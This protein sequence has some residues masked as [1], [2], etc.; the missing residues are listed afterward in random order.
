[1]NFIVIRAYLVEYS[2]NIMLQV[3]S[4]NWRNSWFASLVLYLYIIFDLLSGSTRS[5]VF[6]RDSEPN[7]SNSSKWIHPITFD[8]HE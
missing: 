7:Q 1:M 2:T 3:S 6:S 5:E 4:D 8:F